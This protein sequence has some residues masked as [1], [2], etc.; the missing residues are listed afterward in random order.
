VLD[1]L[2][3]GKDLSPFWY[4]KIAAR[5][6]PVIEELAARGLLHRPRSLPQFLSRPDAQVR[7]ERMRNAPALS[8]LI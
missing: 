2:R 1:L 4:G 6:I 3:A 8:Q 7:I 5:H